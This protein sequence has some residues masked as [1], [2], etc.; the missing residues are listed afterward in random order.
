MKNY[1][2]IINHTVGEIYHYPIEN[3][4]KDQAIIHAKNNYAGWGVRLSYNGI[5]KC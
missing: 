2:E 1:H 5:V 4:T 3:F